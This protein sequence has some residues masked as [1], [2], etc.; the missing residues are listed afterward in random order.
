MSF[1]AGDC[2]IACAAS[3]PEITADSMQP[4]S[5]PLAV[6]SPAIVR[7]SKDRSSGDSRLAGL[8]GSDST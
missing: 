1:S 6:Q 7:L 4:V 2:E 5:S 8:P 3:R